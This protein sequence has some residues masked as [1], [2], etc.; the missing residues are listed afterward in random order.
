M[1]VL[2]TVVVIE[3]LTRLGKQRLDVFPDPLSPITDDAQA[4]LFFCNQAGLFALLERR[5]ELLLVLDLMPTE[6]R[7]DVLPIQ[8]VKAK[9]FRV[10][11]L[12]S[13]PRPP[14]P[15][16][17]A[18]SRV[19]GRRRDASAQT[20]HRCPA[21]ITGRR[22]P[23]AATSAMRRSISRVRGHLHHRQTSAYLVGYGVHPFAPKRQGLSDRERAPGPCHM[24][25]R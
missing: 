23:P 22:K 10:T 13:P 18:P 17:S 1:E 16:G 12:S 19:P 3:P 2:G 21:P 14:G 20:R 15:L 8:Q 25:L 6:P 5:A 9:P 24:G 11:P 4:Y 7:D